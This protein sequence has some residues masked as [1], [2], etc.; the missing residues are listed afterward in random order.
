MEAM[1][2]ITLTQAIAAMCADRAGRG[3][4]PIDSKPRENCGAAA[5]GM[6]CA[7]CFTTWLRSFAGEKP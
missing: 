4:C 7:G 2:R 1:T 6:D 3:E 5:H